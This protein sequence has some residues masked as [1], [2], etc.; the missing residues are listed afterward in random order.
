MTEKNRVLQYWRVTLPNGVVETVEAEK[1]DCSE[2]GLRF[3]VGKEVI[4]WFLVWDNFRKV[5]DPKKIR[6]PEE[7]PGEETHNA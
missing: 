2:N 5:P 6:E 4:A 3:F 1:W 7:E